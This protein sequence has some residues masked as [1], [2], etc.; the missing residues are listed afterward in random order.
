MK[1]TILERYRRNEE[2]TIIIDIA[3]ESITELYNNWDRNAPYVKKDLDPNLVEYIDQS[4]NEIGREPFLI[5]FSLQE[6]ATGDLQQRLC[7]SVANYFLY[8][9]ELERH[10]FMASIRRA[11]ILLL[12]GLIIISASVWMNRGLPEDA[13]VLQ[14]VVAEGLT[15]AGWVSVWEALATF[16][17][18]INPYRRVMHRCVRIAQASIRFA[19]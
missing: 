1:K 10:K 3:A 17:L 16:L 11:L 15:I 7:R 6:V 5:Q 13:S 2:G 4:V 12:A 8:L 14:L 9:K 19:V 18:D